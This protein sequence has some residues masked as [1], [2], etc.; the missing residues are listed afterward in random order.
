MKLNNFVLTSV[1]ALSLAAC[2][3]TSVIPTDSSLF[4]SEQVIA[5]SMRSGIPEW[6][7]SDTTFDVN[8]DGNVYL[9]VM[10]EAIAQ[11]NTDVSQLYRAAELEGKAMFAEVVKQKI[12]AFVQRGRESGELG[13]KF[14]DTTSSWANLTIS[15]LAPSNRYW[16]KVAVPEESNEYTLKYRIY[17]RLKLKESDLREAVRKAINGDTEISEDLKR[18]MLAQEDR[19]FK[20]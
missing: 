10:N 17:V 12:D 14:T 15:N 9:V 19:I 6:A 18:H 7:E 3:S 20:D 13:G 8:E 2:S 11:K 1:V 4:K 16:E 5:T